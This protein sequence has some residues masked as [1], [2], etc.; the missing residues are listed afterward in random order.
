MNVCGA[1]TMINIRLHGELS[2]NKAAFEDMLCCYPAK[3]HA[4]WGA[5]VAL[6][7]ALRIHICGLEK[8]N[9][10]HVF[11]DLEKKSK[12]KRRVNSESGPCTLVKTRLRV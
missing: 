1:A 10:T 8:R 9:H 3:M 5:A 7:C 2:E 12:C 11:L 4:A 6:C